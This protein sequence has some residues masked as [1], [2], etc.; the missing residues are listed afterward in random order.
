[1]RR[2]L[3]DRTLV[4]VVSDHGEEFWEHGGV[5]HG[6]TLY[7]EVLHV[8]WLM[9][10]PDALRAGTR[11]TDMVS[12]VDLVPTVV[13]LAGIAPGDETDGVSLV[14][15]LNGEPSMPRA[16]I[17][18]NLLFA[19]ERVS[20]RTATA[21]L[22]RWAN[23][24]EEVY[25]LRHDPGEQRDLAGDESFAAPLRDEFARVDALLAPAI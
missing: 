7:D 9:R 3:A 6:H 1:D 24:K 14:P 2:G 17:S 20:M 25:D 22:V 12:T 13:E 8:V 11:L 5:E 18:E 16:L 19:E 10:W 23:G 21:K 15:A 4:V